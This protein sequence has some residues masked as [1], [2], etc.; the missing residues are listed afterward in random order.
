MVQW[1]RL[2]ASNAGGPGSIF[3]QGA[4]FCMHAATK[5]SH[6]ATKSPH[7]ATKKSTC[8]TKK[9]ACCNEHPTCPN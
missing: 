9:S 4:R 5:N 1:I 7:A 3:G 6:S 8:P 2:H